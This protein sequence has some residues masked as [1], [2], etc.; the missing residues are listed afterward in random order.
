MRL[1]KLMKVTSMSVSGKLASVPYRDLNNQKGDPFNPVRAQPEDTHHQGDETHSIGQLPNNS[2]R[3]KERRHCPQ[4]RA[5]P[6]TIGYGPI[7]GFSA[8]LITDSH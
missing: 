4:E 7:A 2:E 1:S 6:H 8:V 5:M 3:A